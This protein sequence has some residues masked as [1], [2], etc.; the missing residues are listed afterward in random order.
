MRAPTRARLSLGSVTGLAVT[1]RLACFR[2]RPKRSARWPL[3][4]W[5]ATA[6]TK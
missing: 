1:T 5:N 6:A 4:Y 2:R 3:G